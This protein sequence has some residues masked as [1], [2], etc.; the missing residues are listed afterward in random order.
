MARKKIPCLKP[1]DEELFIGIIFGA[2]GRTK[3]ILGTAIMAKF[4]V[5]D[6]IGSGRKELA[7][8]EIERIEHS[9]A[10]SRW[11]V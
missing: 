6:C 11:D 5:L 1:T 7:A 10:T 8:A 4:I 9:T 3:A 2:G